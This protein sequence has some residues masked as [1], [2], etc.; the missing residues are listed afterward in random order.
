M[1]KKLVSCGAVSCGKIFEPKGDGQPA[2][3]ICP[4]CEEKMNQGIKITL[5]TY[6]GQIKG[7]FNL[8]DKLARR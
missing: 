8:L 5:H 4:S 2:L 6:T 7:N 1:D 3:F